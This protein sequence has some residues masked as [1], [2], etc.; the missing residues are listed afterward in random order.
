[1]GVKLRSDGWMC[2]RVTM[3]NIAG[4]SKRPPKA[5]TQPVP[6]TDFIADRESKAYAVAIDALGKINW[7]SNHI[8][9]DHLI[10]VLTEQVTNDYLAFLQSKKISYLFGGKTEI[11]LGQTLEIVGEGIQD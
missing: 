6:R 11:N 1:V 8:D 5:S 3:G 2:G 4:K 9:S 10:T 7:R